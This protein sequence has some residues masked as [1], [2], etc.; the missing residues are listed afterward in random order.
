MNPTCLQMEPQLKARYSGYPAE[1]LL[2]QGK[3]VVCPLLFALVLIQSTYAAS[4]DCQK[5][6]SRIEK[7]IC[8]D[9][10]ASILDSDLAK[11]Y[12]QALKQSENR[13]KEIDEQRQWLK[14]TRDACQ[15]VSCL[16]N[17]YKTRIAAL[18][19]AT[20]L[21]KSTEVIVFSCAVHSKKVVSLCASK[22]AGNDVGYMQYRFGRDNSSIEFKYPQRKVSPKDAFKYYSESFSK[23]GTA[24]ISFWSNE[25]R[26]SLF[27]TE[28]A[29]GYNGAGIILDRGHPPIRVSF[30][31]CTGTPIIY[32]EMQSPIPFF[33]LDHFGL[34]KAG[35]DISYIGAEP[36][37]DEIQPKPGEPEDWHLRVKH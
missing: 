35:N 17:A 33:S 9:P 5:A 31:K 36:G 13:Q 34:P 29:F 21:C 26:Y 27:Y 37:S 10:M 7:L 11:A 1:Y 25:Y 15:D 8:S 16:K 24:A 32:N 4:F 2:S 6:Q 14:E 18:Q 12:K 23:G 30:Q 19:Q 3:T 20:T 22:V 28:S